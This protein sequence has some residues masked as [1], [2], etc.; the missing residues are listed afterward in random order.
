MQERVRNGDVALIKVLG[1][2]NPADAF[3]KYLDVASME[4]ALTRMNVSFMDG[5]AAI[6]PS[7]MGLAAAATSQ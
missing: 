3:T 7:T 2:E 1:T 6:A 5:R 4:R